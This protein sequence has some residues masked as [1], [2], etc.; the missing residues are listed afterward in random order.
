MRFVSYLILI[1]LIGGFA[2][3]SRFK[4]NN[5]PCTNDDK[6][7]VQWSYDI[8]LA[9]IH[10]KWDP[11]YV[12]DSFISHVDSLFA[13][14]I[15]K[16]TSS[17]YSNNYDSF[18]KNFLGNIEIVSLNSVNSIFK[19][20]LTSLSL[21]TKRNQFVLILCSG[22]KGNPVRV[23]NKNENLFYNNIT[24][25]WSNGVAGV[26]E[27]IKNKSDSIFI[28]IESCKVAKIKLDYRFD[29]GYLDYINDSIFITFTNYG[30]IM[31]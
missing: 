16:G 7:V 8:R 10:N 15:I 25:D 29:F 2:F 9:K 1:S 5:K 26:V 13:D 21:M 4:N 20:G 24:T 12:Y 27:I 14:S 11:Y 17:S 19:Y 31:D 3:C 18:A 30:R 28:T 23:F 6:L 22:F